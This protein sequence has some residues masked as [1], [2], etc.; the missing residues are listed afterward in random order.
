MDRFSP[1]DPFLFEGN[2]AQ[3][4]KL[5]SKHFEFFLTATESSE[6]SDLIKTSILLTTIGSKGR[7]IYETFT[8]NEDESMKLDIV[9]RKF[10]DY[11]K[12]R[13]NLTMSR[14]RFLSYRQQEGE[15]FNDLLVALRKL[16]A[17][18]EFGTIHDELLKDIIVCG[19]SDGSVR[20][21]LLRESDLTLPKAISA[22]QV[23]E[24]TKD[25]IR[26]LQRLNKETHVEDVRHVEEVRQGSVGDVRKKT[27]NRNRKSNSSYKQELR[28]DYFK[29]CKFCGSSHRRGDGPAF[30][31]KCHGCGRK[32]H[33][34]RCCLKKKVNS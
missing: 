28:N 30:G 32:N 5:W 2:L 19:I 1:P 11:C 18:C 25:N 20:A 23:A 3:G 12:P 9:L 21:R 10:A 26:E 7:D 15:S 4:W 34:E 27:S 6:K 24:E 14:Y 33:F 22:C 31:K 8:F 16:G 13:K 29:E 17:E